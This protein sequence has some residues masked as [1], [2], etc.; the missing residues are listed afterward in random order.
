VAQSP[1][2]VGMWLGLSESL[3]LTC[4][5][6]ILFVELAS[7]A[8]DRWIRA[9]RFLFGLACL[10]LGL[11]HFVYADVTASM[12]PSWLPWRMGFAYLTG[13]GHIA[14]GLAILSGTLARLG[15]TLEAAM[16]S[17][18]VLLVHMPGV[19][20]APSGRLQWTML[21]VASAQAGAAW[22]VAGSLKRAPQKSGSPIRFGIASQPET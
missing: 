9:A 18:F 8:G 7:V 16:I 21:F 3:V 20:A 19:A 2:D 15:A 5:G 1:R 10:V 12:V 6:C 11:S 13:A 17:L 4:G 14:A 22:V